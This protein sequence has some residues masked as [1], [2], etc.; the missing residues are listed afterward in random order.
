MREDETVSGESVEGEQ[1]SNG[2]GEDGADGAA[3]DFDTSGV[4]IDAE[5]SPVPSANEPL[6]AAFTVCNTGTAAGTAHVTIEVDG[7][8]SGVSWD[9]PSLEPG[10]CASPDGDGYVHG[11]AGQSE[12]SHAFEAVATPA[13]PG[14]GRSG[15]NTIDIGPPESTNSTEGEGP[16]S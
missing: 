16:D 15:V 4:R 5:D 11:I 13:G 1:T 7:Q 2:D 12:G 8:D 14:G 3:F 6:K 10:D 9:S